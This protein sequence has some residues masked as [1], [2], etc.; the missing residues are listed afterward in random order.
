MVN[1]KLVSMLEEQ[2]T[3]GTTPA[4]PFEQGGQVGTD[5]RVASPPGAP[6]DPIPIVGTPMACDLGVPQAGDLTMNGSAD[7]L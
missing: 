5:R 2:P 1:L 3:I 6:I 7:E 4:L